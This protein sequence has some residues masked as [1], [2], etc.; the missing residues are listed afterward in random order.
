MRR[1]LRTFRSREVVYNCFKTANENKKICSVPLRT[2]SERDERSNIKRIKI[3]G[4]V[5]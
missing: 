2:L 3:F 5:N 1:L 4:I